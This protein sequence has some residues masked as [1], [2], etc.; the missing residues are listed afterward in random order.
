MNVSIKMKTS[1][2]IELA[3]QGLLWYQIY[4]FRRR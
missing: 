1:F 4:Q 3:A 2:Q